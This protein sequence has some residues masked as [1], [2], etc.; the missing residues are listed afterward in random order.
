SRSRSRPPAE[1][2][3][4][5]GNDRRDV[6]RILF[7][8]V[9][10]GFVITAALPPRV[11]GWD[12]FG[13]MVVAYAAYQDLTPETKKRANALVRRNPKYKMW[14]TWLPAGASKADKDAMLFMIAATWPDQIKSDASYTNDGD[15]GGNRPEGSPDPG[16]NHGYGDKLRHKY[17]HF[18]DTPFSRDGT[19]LP[20]VPTP[21]AG[22][23][24]ALFRTVLTSTA[25]DP[26]KSYDLV[27]LLHL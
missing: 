13:H 17:W 3:M 24:I 27:W 26:L 2:P 1:G 11:Y 16:G 8:S 15:H 4:S 5:F 22:E 20:P 9:L 7:A 12:S 10:V 6:V 23:R 19:A 14:L 18:V 25:P 21:N